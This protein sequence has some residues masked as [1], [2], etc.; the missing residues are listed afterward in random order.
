M[1]CRPRGLCATLNKG[2]FQPGGIEAYLSA[3]SIVILSSG[4]VF[5]ESIASRLRQQLAAS[6]FQT[7]DSRQA[8][9][10]QQVIA[11]QPALVIAEAADNRLE[12]VCPLNSLLAA[13]PKLT[14]IRLDAQQE[15]MQVVT[16]E[17]RPSSGMNGLIAVIQSAV[18]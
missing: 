10:L 15:R 12:Q 14:V 4:S 7:I 17:H 11:A 16:S 8:D 6:K 1:G 13:L 3:A 9:A 5:V 18:G 2:P